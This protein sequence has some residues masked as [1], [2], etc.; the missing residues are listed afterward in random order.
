MADA[1]ATE[2]E[3]GT[4][5]FPIQLA[6]ELDGTHVHYITREEVT[7]GTLPEG[8]AGTVVHPVAEAGFLCV[9]EGPFSI[10]TVSSPGIF[11]PGQFKPGTG[12]TGALLNFESEAVE[13]RFIGSWVVRAG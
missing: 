8:C 4:I 9:F 10:G 12:V 3:R 7:K 2:N 13:S 5:S 1:N 11:A 6:S